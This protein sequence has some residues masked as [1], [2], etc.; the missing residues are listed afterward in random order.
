MSMVI[1]SQYGHG[2]IFSGASRARVVGR[3]VGLT[4][5]TKKNRFGVLRVSSLRWGEAKSPLGLGHEH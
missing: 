2:W 1:P 5:P 3:V 4:N